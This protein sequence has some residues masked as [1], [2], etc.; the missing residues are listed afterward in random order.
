MLGKIFESLDK[1][2]IYTVGGILVGVIVLVMIASLAG[3]GGKTKTNNYE[4]IKKTMVNAAKEYYT[5]PINKRKLPEDGEEKELQIAPLV[6]L[7]LMKDLSEY[8]SKDVTCTGKIIIRN[9]ADEYTYT[10]VLDCGDDFSEV[11]LAKYLLENNPVVTEGAGIYDSGTDFYYRGEVKNNYVQIGVNI[12]RILSIDKEDNV[13]LVFQ[14]STNEKVYRMKEKVWDNR[15]NIV[16]RNYS[17]KNEF[18]VSRMKEELEL[19]TTV[20]ELVDAELR[21]KL[22]KAPLC[23]SPRAEDVTTKDGSIECSILSKDT[24]YFGAIAAYEYLRISLDA[25]CLQTNST[26]CTNYNFLS[27]NR[28]IWTTTA[29]TKKTNQV[30][31]YGYTGLKSYPANERKM[32]YP[33]IILNNS[34]IKVEG[35]GSFEKPYLVK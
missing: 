8:T 7:G 22:V 1:K 10:P 27:S 3:G 28:L 26:V 31:A 35:N 21:A 9:I 33:T 4:S 13:K 34:T 14:K 12:W 15:Y 29:A 11:A 24:Y 18:E 23:I 5:D 19:Y 6:R 32:I 25:A 30:Y 2:F 20:T 17:G 16:E